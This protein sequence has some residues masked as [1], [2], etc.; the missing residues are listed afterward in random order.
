MPETVAE[1]ATIIPPTTPKDQIRRVAFVYTPKGVQGQSL[2]V[3]FLCQAARTIAKKPLFLRQALNLEVT[4][5]SDP[6]AIFHKAREAR[7]VSVLAIVDDWPPAKIEALSDACARGGLMF[8]SVPSADV[9]KKSTAV[10]VI[11]DMMLLPGES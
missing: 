5:Q 7:A 4:P 8:R 3:E 2:L 1:S 6:E 11:V 10:D 9:Q